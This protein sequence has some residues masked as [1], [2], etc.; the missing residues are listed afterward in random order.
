MAGGRGRLGATNAFV[1]FAI[2]IF[3]AQNS[4]VVVLANCCCCPLAILLASSLLCR[5][6]ED[7]PKKIEKRKEKTLGNSAWPK[8]CPYVC[9]CVFECACVGVCNFIV[10]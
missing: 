1:V 9:V 8:T 3:F 4:I 5:N 6:V 10:R 7:A 2:E